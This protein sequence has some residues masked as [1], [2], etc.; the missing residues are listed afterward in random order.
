[1]EPCTRLQQGR[2]PVPWILRLRDHQLRR[3][4]VEDCS[5]QAR[6]G[7]GRPARRLHERCDSFGLRGYRGSQGLEWGAFAVFVLCARPVLTPT[8]GC[9]DLEVGQ[10]GDLSRMK[11]TCIGRFPDADST[12]IKTVRGSAFPLPAS[13]SAAA[14][15]AT[16]QYPGGSVVSYA[17]HQWTAGWC[18]SSYGDTCARIDG[19]LQVEPGQPARRCRGVRGRDLRLLR[20]DGQR[21]LLEPAVNAEQSL[22]RSLSLSRVTSLYS[23]R[24]VRFPWESG[25]RC[26]FPRMV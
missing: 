22:F 15:S 17:G 19:P 26:L 10:P 25:F 8:I 7:R 21:R 3:A 18:A 11:L 20:L 16:D 12:W 9:D 6:D 24:V 23:S 2:H 5:W 13:C 1:M 14:W 4:R